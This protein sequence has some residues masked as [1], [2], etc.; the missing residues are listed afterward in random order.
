MEAYGNMQSSRKAASSSNV[1]KFKVINRK[2]SARSLLQKSTL[3]QVGSG[4]STLC[5][6]D[7]SS[8]S[9][10]NLDVI[11]KI[12]SSASIEKIGASGLKNN[13]LD[14][15]QLSAPNGRKRKLK[16]RLFKRESEK[17]QDS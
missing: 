8:K 3:S 5:R 2:S 6:Q 4:G 14:K 15:V 9:T 13:S 10:V 16:I 11:R 1:K 12:A 7:G 17:L